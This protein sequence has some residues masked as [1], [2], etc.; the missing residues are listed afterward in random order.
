MI[1]APPWPEDHET[2]SIARACHGVDD[3]LQLAAGLARRFHGW[4]EHER[5]SEPGG[6]CGCRFEPSDVLDAA[7]SEFLGKLE[8][9]ITG[10]KRAVGFSSG[11]MLG[12]VA[13]VLAD[14]LGIDQRPHA[15]DQPLPSL[16]TAIAEVFRS[17]QWFSY[18]LMGGLSM[19]VP[20][21]WRMVERDRPTRWSFGN[22]VRWGLA[23]AAISTIVNGSVSSGLAVFAVTGVRRPVRRTLGQGTRDFAQLRA[24]GQATFF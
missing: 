12:I 11:A 6:L 13:A 15:M 5:R 9:S 2:P 24:D 7:A 3:R 21:W 17:G 1:E 20:R 14:W 19:S 18:A 8:K 16:P 22:L 4:R 10:R 23:S